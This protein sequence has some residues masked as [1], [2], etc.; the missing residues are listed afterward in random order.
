M[1]NRKIISPC[2][3]IC[4]TNPSTGF[5]FGCARNEEEKK[6]W[7]DPN[8]TN[9]WKEENLK[10]IISRMTES[11]IKTFNQSY[12]EKIQFG[13]LVYSKKLKNKP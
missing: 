6:V 3:S 7:K 5:C 4:K 12:E 1:N 11:Q 13:K 9:E 10:V 8:T 2:I